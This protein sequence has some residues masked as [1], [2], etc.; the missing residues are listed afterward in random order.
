LRG[1]I[2]RRLAVLP[3]VVLGIT[4]L[5][6]F[7]S[8]L[9]PG[10]PAVVFAGGRTRASPEVIAQ[11]RHD[12]GLDRPIIVQYLKYLGRL[13]HGDFGYSFPD[14]A[15]VV[16]LVMRRLPATIEV[17]GMALLIGVPIGLY[18]G[19]RAAWKQ[20]SL[21]DHA[22]NL[23]SITGIALPLFWVPLLFIY[24]FSVQLGWLPL[25]GRLPAFSQFQGIT[26]IYSLDAL[27]RGDFSDLWIILRHLA[28]PALT[29]AIIP[30][31]ILARFGRAIFLDVLGENYIRTAFAYGI[32]P[33]T[34]L[35][36]LAGKNAMLPLI[37]LITLLIPALIVGS[38][39]I[40][41]IFSW[42]GIGQFLLGALNTR[43]YVVIQSLTL[44]VGLLY[45][46]LNLIADISYA[47]LDP[48]TRRS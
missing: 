34:I 46:V 14:Q 43:N 15:S 16:T 8:R 7:I 10:D 39:L 4:M 11:I 3:L 19:V 42:P 26:G 41:S 21:T 20:G 33:R 1:L 47:I 24:L 29:L 12:W 5:V 6:F 37:T 31:A 22:A 17:T 32:R 28:L 36:R 18:M 48:R 45:V 25:S 2:L 30:A 9:I 38:V 44:M 35:W 27:I 23:L 13:A 40:E